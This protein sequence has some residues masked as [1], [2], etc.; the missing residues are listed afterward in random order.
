MT[1][2]AI[3]GAGGKMGCR[4]SANLK[5]RKEYVVAH[6]EVSVEGAA[7]LEAMG[8]GVV[9][10]ES[11]IP[12]ADV[13]ILAVPDVLIRKITAEMVPMMKP[14]SMLLG[15]DPAAAYAEVMPI[16]EDI[17]YFVAHPSHP[18]IFNNETDPAAQHDYFGGTARQSALC[19]LH[20]GPEADY[21]K[22]E[23]LTRIIY[24]PVDRTFQVTV[25][26]MAILEPALVETLS[27]TLIDALKE[28]YE[29]VVKMGVPRDAALDFVLGHARI[30][31][32]VLFGFADFTFSD[33]ALLAMEK[34]RSLIFKE[35]W[36]EK[37]FSID[38]VK[39]S[40]RAIT[41]SQA[42]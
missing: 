35:D 17:T 5:D 14:G 3:L 11:A 6:I 16:R 20:R 31:F 4:I 30:Q 42:G 7:R 22:G 2:I 40:V 28:G 29:E 34:A 38:K 21:A 12:D 37:I 27:S 32:A 19:A 39:E 10:A 23:R 18:T 33:G 8:F 13:V 24:A 9:S 1:K 25:E 36:K 15:L 26:Q 41:N